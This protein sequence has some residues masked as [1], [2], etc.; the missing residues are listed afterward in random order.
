[1]AKALQNRA[2]SAK[3]AEASANQSREPFPLAQTLT[4]QAAQD[5]LQALIQHSFFRPHLATLL[6][7]FASARLDLLVLK[8]AA[9]SETIYPRPSLRRYGDLDVLV[10]PTDIGRARTLLET[11]GYTVDPHQWEVLAGGRD[12]QANFF[13]YAERGAVVV[14]LHT[15]LINND[16]FFGQIRVDRAGL[17]TRAHPARLAG[18][19][20]RVLGPEDQLLHLCLH[21][22]GHYFAAPQSLRDIAQVCGAQRIDWPLFVTIAQGSRAATAC[23]CG[24]FAAGLLG[25]DVP[26]TVL[27]ALAPRAMRRRLEGLTAE[28]V[29]DIAGT[30]T[31]HLRFPLLWLLLD[32]PA[33]RFKALRGIVFPSV[34]WLVTHY[35]YEL[36]DDPD[37][38]TLAGRVRPGPAEVLRYLRT[39]STLYCAHARFLLR[40]LA[41]NL[42]RGKAID[43]P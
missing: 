18:E 39:V 32:G 4:E 38:P 2:E 21:L 29:S 40:G 41:R 9:L 5:E 30:R 10:R 11:L 22:A 15:D 19:E 27:D 25:A 14:E 28:R 16:L 33:G 43:S 26:P 37:P 42:R 36:Y 17:W 8:G 24:L 23:F 1:M 34:P 3:E 6:T 35:Y 7:V 13:K 12:C 20:A 31:E